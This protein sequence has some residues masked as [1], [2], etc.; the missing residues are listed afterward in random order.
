MIDLGEP[1]LF[2][3]LTHQLSQEVA[4]FVIRLGL[5]GRQRYAKNLV[6][7]LRQFLQH[8][9]AGAPQ[10]D[11]RHPVVNTVQTAIAQQVALLVLHAVLVQEAE[12]GTQSASV[13][14]LDHGEKFL[15]FVLQGRAG[16]HEG[17][18]ALQLLDGARGCGGPVADALRLIEDDQVRAQ[19]VHIPHILEDQFIAGEGEEG[20]VRVER[21]PPGQQPVDHLRREIRELFDFRFPLV[22]N[23]SGS[24]H[25]HSLDSLTAAQEFDRGQRLHCF[26]QTHIVGQDHAT[27]AGR[28][29]GAVLLVGQKLGLQNIGNRVVPLLELR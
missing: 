25:Q 19:C 16:E 24:D 10:Q 22:F 29:Q 21:L 3:P 15:Q 27:T 14:E 17:I 2:F 6:G 20:G 11:R 23:G 13:D 12:G 26:P 18:A 28:E 4:L 7:P 5:L 8:L 1:A 9:G